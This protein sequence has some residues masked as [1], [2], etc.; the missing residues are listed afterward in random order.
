MFRRFFG[1]FGPGRFSPATP[2]GSAPFEP[3]SDP[4]SD[5]RFGPRRFGPPH[6]FGPFH[7][8]RRGPEDFFGFGPPFGRRGGFGPGPERFFEKGDL[9]YV[10]LDLLKDQPRHGYDVI[11]ALEERLGGFYNPSPGSVYPTLQLLEDQ[12]YLTSNQL[13]GKR[14]Y[15][16]TDDGRKFLG[17]RAEV[18]EGLKA[19]M[20]ARRGFGQQPEAG[21]LFG[22]MRQLGMLLFRLGQSGALHDPD[23]MRRLR[24]IVVHARR[25]VEA[26]INDAPAGTQGEKK[27]NDQT[28]PP[29]LV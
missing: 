8:R 11:R 9:K 28:W 7:H 12:G 13:D 21:E 29:E 15:A 14:V 1:P 4:R 2:W 22:E 6:H 27:A 20:D 5:S 3:D 26:I 16:I 17:E 25:E 18:I 19:R 23:R 10:I 24:E